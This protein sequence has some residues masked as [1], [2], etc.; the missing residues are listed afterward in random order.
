MNTVKNIK[1][2]ALLDRTGEILKLS[3]AFP[4][5]P[6][7][8]DVFVT[9]ADFYDWNLG[10]QADSAEKYKDKIKRVFY[11]EE[12]VGPAKVM[13]QDDVRRLELMG[14]FS[15]G[16]KV[17]EVG[18]SDGSASVKIATNKEVKEILAIDLRASAISEGK[19]MLKDLQNRGEI[20]K[21]V[22][23]K[24][25]LKKSA[26]EKLPAS[27]GQFDSVCAYEVF[28]HL[29]PWD[30]V[31]VFLKVY[32]FIKPQGK[33]FISVPNRFH[34]EKYNQEGRS[35]WSWFDHR[36]FFSQASLE[37][38]LTSFFENVKFYPLYPSEKPGDS[39]YLIC[40]CYGKKV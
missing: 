19:A 34:H 32:D 39:I 3:P 23:K 37:L 36:N 14:G 5:K 9:V 26:I 1:Q 29:A 24:I 15:Y 22:A 12:V 16:K 6:K 33:F 27:V 2:V 25:T 30:L 11:E 31:P 28:E 20:K 18:S 8:A 35:R 4:K 21:E 7:S 10:K 38:F 17:L 13:L 40:E